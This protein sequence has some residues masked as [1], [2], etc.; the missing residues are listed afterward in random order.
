MALSYPLTFPTY[1]SKQPVKEFNLRLVNKT[2]LQKSP[3]TNKQTVINYGHAW[4]EA[5][6]KMTPLMGDDARKMS[7]FLQSLRGVLGTFKFTVPFQDG[8]GILDSQG[9]VVATVTGVHNAGSDS[10]TLTVTNGTVAVGQQFNIGDHLYTALETKATG[11]SG[12]IEITPP[13]RTLVSNGTA[14]DFT[15]PFIVFRLAENETKYRVGVDSTH[16]FSISVVE[17]I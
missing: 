13:L 3:F 12:T 7:G 11:S 17:A 8:T 14:I 16:E 10:L 1:N 4:Y 9:T 5:E 15:D 2:V 6:I